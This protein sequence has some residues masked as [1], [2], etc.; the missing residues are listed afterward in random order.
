MTATTNARHPVDHQASVAQDLSV[1]GAYA[2]H[3]R[4]RQ[5]RIAAASVIANLN[6]PGP[7]P[8]PM[9]L[10]RERIGMALIAW[11]TRIEL[12]RADTRSAP[13]NDRVSCTASRT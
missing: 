12:G 3:F 2:P 10:M 4:Y 9:R 11:G 7:S 1:Y 5:E 13:A 8:S 6:D